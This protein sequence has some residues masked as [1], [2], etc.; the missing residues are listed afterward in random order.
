M[1]ASEA[2]ITANI[3]D[4]FATFTLTGGQ[5][6][7]AGTGGDT[8]TH[9]WPAVCSGTQLSTLTAGDSLTDTGP[10]NVL[11]ATF[12]QHH[13][14]TIRSLNIVGIPTWNIDMAGTGDGAITLTGDGGGGPNQIS[15]LKVLNVTFDEGTG[16]LIIGDNSSPV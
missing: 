4:S 14:H 11:N 16:C 3:H 13:D 15:G 5:D 12:N 9:R 8:L 10:G 6:H 7:F 1:V 2:F